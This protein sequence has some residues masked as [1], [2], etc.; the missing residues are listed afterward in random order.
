VIGAH[1]YVGDNLYLGREAVR[2]L[3][4]YLEQRHGRS[5]L[6]AASKAGHVE[7]VQA[8]LKA[9]ADV[10]HTDVRVLRLVEFELQQSK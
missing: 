3:L 4:L 9:G 7:V 6:H 2:C 8:L 5:P 10:R 1:A